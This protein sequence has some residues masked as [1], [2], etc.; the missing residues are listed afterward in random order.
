[1]FRR[2]VPQK[3]APSLTWRSASLD[4]VLGDARLR[5]FKPKFEQLAVDARRSPKR[6]FHAHPPDQRPQVRINLGPP[7]PG[8]RLP[9]PVT[10][11]AGPMPP[12]ER[13]LDDREDLQDR[14]KPAIQLNKEPAIVIRQP[15]PAMHL[16]PQNNQ[17]MSEQRILGFKPAL[18][19]EWRGQDG[20]YETYQRDHGALT[21]CDSFSKSMRMRFSVHTVVFDTV[22]SPEHGRRTERTIRRDGSGSC[23]GSL[24]SGE[25]RSPDPSDRTIYPSY[26]SSRRCRGG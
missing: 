1:M 10:A 21:L 15:D 18:R 19:L 23:L 8:A 20:Q 6:V 2:V 22:F 26:D 4:H 7:S 13:L 3:G 24:V 16:T 25:F 5:D 14:R 11:K 17:L 12:H 9:T